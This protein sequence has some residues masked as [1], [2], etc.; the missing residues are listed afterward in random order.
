MPSTTE[1]SSFHLL[2]PSPTTLPSE[3]NDIDPEDDAEARNELSALNGLIR[4]SPEPDIDADHADPDLPTNAASGLGNALDPE[5]A[6]SH[7][8]DMLEAGP[9]GAIDLAGNVETFS[10]PLA[11]LAPPPMAIWHN[12]S[13]DA[14]NSSSNENIEEMFWNQNP[15]PQSLPPIPMIFDVICSPSK[16]SQQ[17]KPTKIWKEI[18]ELYLPKESGRMVKQDGQTRYYKHITIF[19]DA[20]V[21]ANHWLL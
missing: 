15:C 7:V 6:P 8:D 13:G 4:M 12:Q 19:P 16:S 14:N 11:N 9:D 10:E 2:P 5:V 21:T 3:S 17:Q 20:L 18:M 1:Y